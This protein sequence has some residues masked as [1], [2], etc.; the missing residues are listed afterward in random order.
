MILSKLKEAWICI[1][2]GRVTLPYPF[3]P[4]VPEEGFRG[5]ITVDAEKC[6][7]C[8]GCANV[9]TPRAIQ[10]SDPSQEIRLLEFF[11]ERCTYCAR[12]EEVCPEKAVTCTKEFETAT[13]DVQDL[14]LKV[15][16]FMGTCQRCGRCF[17]TST[18]L[19]KMM[20]TGFR[21]G[22]QPQAAEETA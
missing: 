1:K 14:H 22:K 2:A 11:L 5:R 8:G 21:N 12:C 13:N 10:V 3:A 18:E 20:V 9:C 16:V 6:V 7:G 17:E 15:E 19:D 4:A